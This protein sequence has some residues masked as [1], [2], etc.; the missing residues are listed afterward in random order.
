MIK[1]EEVAG[2]SVSRINWIG[3]PGG[4]SSGSFLSQPFGNALSK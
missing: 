1:H 2:R 3:N 4:F